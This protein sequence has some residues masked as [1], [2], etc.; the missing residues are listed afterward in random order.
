MRRQE[1]LAN[2]TCCNAAQQSHQCC[3]LARCKAYFAISLIVTA[4]PHAASLEFPGFN[5]G[6]LGNG[7]VL[8]GALLSSALGSRLGGGFGLGGGLDGHYE[9]ALA[10]LTAAFHSTASLRPGQQQG[11]G[12]ACGQAGNTTFATCRHNKSMHKC[13]ASIV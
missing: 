9:S 3:A 6:G 5:A 12:G 13:F 4:L 10:Q 11:A 7:G 1:A 8:G 2:C